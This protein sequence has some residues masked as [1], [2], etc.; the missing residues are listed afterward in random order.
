V[1]EPEPVPELETEEGE[2]GL[3]M[4]REIAEMMRQVSGPPPTEKTG[5]AAQPGVVDAEDKEDGE[6]EAFSLEEEVVAEE[7]EQ[8]GHEAT[9]LVLVCPDGVAP[10]DIMEVR[11]PAC[12]SLASKTLH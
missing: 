10:G 6:E 12:I 11:G 3:M 4:A 2:D 5:G 7:E 1:L 8:E 9:Q